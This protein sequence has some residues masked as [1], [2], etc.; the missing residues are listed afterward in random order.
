MLLFIFAVL[1]MLYFLN[2]KDP[3]NFPPGP[4][5]LPLLGNVFS[6]ESKQPHIYLTKLADVYG[7]VFCIRL[8]RHKTVFVSGWKM[9]KEAIVTQAENFV[10]RPYS[11]MV[12]RIY[13]GNS[14]GLF[15]SNGN[16]WR[17]QRR[18]AMA[19]LRTFGLAKSSME[20]SI[21]EESHHLQEAM[22]K[23]K[24]ES[25]DPVPLLNNA[26]ANIICQIVFGRRF[27]YSDS[28]FQSMLKNLTEM[29]YLE[30][31][32]WAFVRFSDTM[33]NLHTAVSIHDMF[34]KANTKI[35][36]IRKIG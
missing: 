14:A 18:F 36:I 12:T 20:Q 17:R 13:S 22:E 15:F 32:I 16:V 24:G 5:A 34:K 21:C 29:A 7:N 33:H 4:P 8:G 23:E 10:D 30:G 27:D 19:M 3:P 31:S 28:S 1:L 6:I 2:K 26:V 11:P 35:R 9:V 25:F